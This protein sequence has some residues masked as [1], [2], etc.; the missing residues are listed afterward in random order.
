[1]NVGTEILVGDELLQPAH[2][3]TSRMRLS[4]ND[5][6]HSLAANSA[7]N[8]SNWQVG[9]TYLGLVISHGA[10]SKDLYVMANSDINEIC[11]N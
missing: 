4:C 3:F 5:G 9:F 1:M 10:F 8:I 2:R 6:L 11:S 7:G